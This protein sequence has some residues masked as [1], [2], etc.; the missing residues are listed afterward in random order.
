MILVTPVHCCIQSPKGV[1]WIA[2]L[3]LKQVGVPEVVDE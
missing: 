3:R 1:G 2:E